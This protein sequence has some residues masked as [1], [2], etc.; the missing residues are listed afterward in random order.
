VAVIIFFLVWNK[1][2]ANL[3][4]TIAILASKFAQPGEVN[5]CR[6]PSLNISLT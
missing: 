1:R 2:G 6:P 3:L 4:W 5:V